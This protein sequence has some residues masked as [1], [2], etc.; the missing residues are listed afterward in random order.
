MASETTAAA[1]G[2][3]G[4][5]RRDPMAMLP[6]CGYNMCDYFAHWLKMG[7]RM[8]NAPKIFHVNWFRTDANGNYIWPGFGDNMRVLDWI[9][10]RC[11]GEVDA[12]ETPVGLMPKKEDI[13]IDG[14]DAFN[15]VKL[16]E[17]L[18]LD[19]SAWKKEAE[20]IS[21]FFDKFGDELPEKLAKQLRILKHNLRNENK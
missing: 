6:F 18:D 14:M 21:E 17:V 2:K 20:S 8:S 16:E 7:V 11:D 5:V 15:D 9:I 1:A 10:R 12:V 19:L 4:V 13:N 3:V